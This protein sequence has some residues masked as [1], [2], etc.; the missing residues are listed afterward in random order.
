MGHQVTRAWL[1]LLLAL[2]PAGA[3]AQRS[4]SPAAAE[5]RNR[6]TDD[7]DL[8]PGAGG[9]FDFIGTRDSDGF[10]TRR[11]RIGALVHHNSAYDFSGVAAGT[12]YYRQDSWSERGYSLWGVLEKRDRAT[13]AGIS[14]HIGLLHVNG[15]D[16]LLADA[17][18]N[19]RFSAQTGSEVIF[20]R[21]VVETR[22]ALDNGVNQNFLG[23]SVDHAF[24]NRLTAVALAGAQQFSDD[25]NRGHLRGWIIYTLAPEYGLAVQLRAR[26]YE[27]S[28]QGSPF[29]FNPERYENV[30]IGL[31][32][33]KRFG[34]WRVRAFLAAGEERIDRGVANPTGFAQLHVDRVLAGGIRIGL[35]YA[36]SHAAGEDRGNA[37]GTYSWRYLRL[38]VVA[39][40]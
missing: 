37:D 40:F 16:H 26:G 15:F 36:Y 8:L 17:V 4:P 7:F 33:N 19:H 5:D 21:D 29:Y 32:L 22:A 1:L 11:T 2:V 39:P 14:A 25:N 35:R 31:R 9:S 38:F 34:A 23:A 3:A 27:N 30:D 24:S 13:A 20:Q 6:A 28:R 10:E 12:D 18:W